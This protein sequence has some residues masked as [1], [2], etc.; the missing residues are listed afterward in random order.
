MS[1]ERK[2]DR[3]VHEILELLK[4]VGEEIP[5]SHWHVAHGLDGYGPNTDPDSDCVRVA[6]F[7]GL[8][9]TIAGELE[10]DLEYIGGQCDTDADAGD[11]DNLLRDYR[12]MRAVR[13]AEVEFTAAVENRDNDFWKDK[14]EKFD[15]RWTAKI[16]QTFPL[17]VSHNTNLHVWVCESPDICEIDQEEQP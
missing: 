7:G 13:D 15:A 6:D 2:M 5:A 3:E 16:F 4:P 11:G 12:F 14:R 10:H 9:R 17:Q 1:D 8:L